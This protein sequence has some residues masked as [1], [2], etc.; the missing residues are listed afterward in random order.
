MLAYHNLV[1]EL[2]ETKNMYCNVYACETGHFIFS[3]NDDQFNKKY[4]N[5]CRIVNLT[6][7]L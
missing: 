3:A 1:I 4:Y 5:N 2:V 6:H 7:S